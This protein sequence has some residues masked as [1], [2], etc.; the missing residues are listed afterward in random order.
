[1]ATWRR[2]TCRGRDA[3]RGKMTEKYEENTQDC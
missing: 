3:V 1:M 2:Q